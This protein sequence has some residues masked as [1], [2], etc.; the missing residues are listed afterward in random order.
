MTMFTSGG[1]SG[2]SISDP[3]MISSTPT[4]PANY[5]YTLL[6]RVSGPQSAST[7]DYDMD[8]DSDVTPSVFE[9]QVPA[10]KTFKHERINFEI[11][12]GSIA[13]NSFGGVAGPLTNG[14]LFEIID[15]DGSTQL[16]DFTG[17]LPIARNAD[18]SLLAGVDTVITPAAGDDHLP[19]RFTVA[20]AGAPMLLT[21]GQR[22]RWT[23]RD[24]ISGITVF[25][26][27]VQ[28]VFTS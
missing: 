4:A 9:Y 8:T 3:I 21:V 18:F 17:G 23:N 5:V 26:A 1:A 13:P 19:I 27:M 7:E 28:G 14:C 25:R 16:L 12:D 20:K 24:D 11:V 22:I 6:T 15:D 2:G 10:G